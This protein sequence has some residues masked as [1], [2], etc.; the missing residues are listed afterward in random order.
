MTGI[1]VTGRC[2]SGRDTGIIGLDLASEKSLFLIDP[3]IK[4]LY[5]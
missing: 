1:L 2:A 4:S 3:S 5:R